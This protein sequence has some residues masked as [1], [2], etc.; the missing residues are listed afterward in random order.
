[1][2]RIF[3]ID[4][5]KCCVG[6]NAIFLRYEDDKQYAR[7][8]GEKRKAV[9]HFCRD[10]L[11]QIV[12]AIQPQQIVTIGFKTLQMFGPTTKE[13]VGAKRTI[14]KLGTVFDRPA[15]GLIHLSSGRPSNADLKA[16]ADYFK[17]RRRGQEQA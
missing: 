10:C 11:R 13:L 12:E 14:I 16:I 2:Q 1:M 4:L 17:R 3:E 9:E 5:L 8:V 15:I 6:T 7:S